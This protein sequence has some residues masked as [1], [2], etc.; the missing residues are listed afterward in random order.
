MTPREKTVL[1]LLTSYRT[2]PAMYSIMYADGS[3]FF[4]AAKELAKIFCVKPE[5]VEPL[6]APYK[7][8]ITYAMQDFRHYV[9]LLKDVPTFEDAYWPSMDEEAKLI[10]NNEPF[11]LPLKRPDIL[12]IGC[13]SAPYVNKFKAMCGR[14]IHYTMVDKRLTVAK[15]QSGIT[16]YQYAYDYAY[17]F[18]SSSIRYR[19]YNVLF[20]ANFLHCVEDVHTFFKNYLPILPALRFIKIIE[21]K[22]DSPMNLLFGYHMLVHCR[23]QAIDCE[24]L[25]DIAELYGR[26]MHVQ[27]LGEHHNMY[28]IVL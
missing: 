20:L 9:E 19:A 14:H 6:L 26:Q 10:T 15:S 5:E 12:D 16:Y 1:T 23:G 7:A 27:S 8:R 18:K 28:T 3:I 13:G 22:P 4:A 21:I 24:I 2:I 17:F 11:R 25:K